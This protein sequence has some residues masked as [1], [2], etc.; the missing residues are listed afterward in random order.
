MKI[1]KITCYTASNCLNVPH[2]HVDYYIDFLILSNCHAGSLNTY[3]FDV[4]SGHTPGANRKGVGWSFNIPTRLTQKKKKKPPEKHHKHPC[5]IK[6]MAS[7][8]ITVVQYTENISPSSLSF[9]HLCLRRS[10]AS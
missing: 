10:K 8:S 4:N 7:C 9:C 6:P 2:S 1:A 5:K 3:L